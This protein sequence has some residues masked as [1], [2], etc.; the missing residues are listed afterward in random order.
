MIGSPD[1]PQM[2]SGYGMRN[3]GGYLPWS[4]AEERLANSRNYWIA[5]TRPDGRP[6]VMPV[7][8]VWLEGS[9]IFGTDR[10]SRKGRNLAANPAVAVH[11][12]S[13]DEAVIIEGV[14]EELADAG[15]LQVADAAYMAK[16]NQSLLGAPGDVV[17]YQVRPA[18]AFA[19]QESDFFRATRWRF[20]V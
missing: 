8:G 1:R 7:W 3:D 9:V 14:A 19:W 13:G 6:H 4:W 12:E 16:Y 15:M 18:V 17:I 11:L 10:G 2:P 20:P 5:T